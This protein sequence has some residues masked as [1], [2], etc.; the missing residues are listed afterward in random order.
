MLH[1]Q[2]SVVSCKWPNA[3]MIGCMV[4][5]SRVFRNNAPKSASAAETATSLRIASVIAILL[6]SLMLSQMCG[7]FQRKKYPPALL[8]P[9]DADRYL[10]SEYTLSSMSEAQY[11]ITAFGL[12]CI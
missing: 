3:Q 8:L 1:S 10:A 6:F 7:T 2:I 5:S 11:I 9:C 4:S 12:V